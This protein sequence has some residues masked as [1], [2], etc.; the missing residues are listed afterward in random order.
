[1]QR[2][3]VGILAVL[4]MA[5]AAS[6]QTG[7][8]S[9]YVQG[10]AGVLR[11]PDKTT[12]LFGGEV[13]FEV[14]DNL[15]VFGNIGFGLNIFPDDELDALQDECDAVGADCDATARLT[16]ATGGAKYLFP[17]GTTVRP[18]AAGGV[19]VAR[20]SVKIEADGDD[21]T[22]DVEDLVG[23]LSD[24]SGLLEVG[25]GIELAVG[26]NGMVDIG[27]RL[28]KVF[29]DDSDVGHRVY[30]GFGWRF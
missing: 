13:G 26:G 1:M 6:A 12:G 11:A 9:G 2:T 15:A 16:F 23:E 5:S 17:T 30:G 4:L 3:I 29:E 22:D 20:R 28:M 24:T 19:G 10:F 18:Y 21:I 8:G 14:I 27:Y 7:S 25:G